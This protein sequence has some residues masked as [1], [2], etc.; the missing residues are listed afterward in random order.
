MT[1]ETDS[2]DPGETGSS[3]WRRGGRGIAVLFLTWTA[4]AMAFTMIPVESVL[5]RKVAPLFERFRSITGLDQH[6]DM[7]ASVPNHRAYVVTVEVEP[8]SGG[9]WRTLE[10]I[11][12]VLPGL[13]PLPAYFRYHSFY[14]RL[15]QK[16]YAG[17]MEPYTRALAGEIVRAHPGLEGGRFRLRKS[18][19]RIQAL[20]TIRDLGEVSYEQSTLN[21]PYPLGDRP[22]R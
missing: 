22:N 8:A 18:A 5:R 10:T 9:G 21:G 7:F 14:N 13:E 15:D 3:P 19:Q 16:R 1:E 11:G 12:P 6:W 17:G 4:L 20:E 2:R